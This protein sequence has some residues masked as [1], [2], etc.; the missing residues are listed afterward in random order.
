MATWELWAKSH[1]RV[2]RSLVCRA[3]LPVLWVKLCA[4]DSAGD[5]A[6]GSAGDSAGDNAGDSAGAEEALPDGSPEPVNERTDADLRSHQALPSDRRLLFQRLL[7][8]SPRFLRQLFKELFPSISVL[9]RQALCGA[10]Q[11][12]CQGNG[13]CTR[14]EPWQDTRWGPTAVGALAGFWGGSIGGSQVRRR[15]PSGPGDRGPVA[16]SG[17]ALSL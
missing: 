11:E 5:S 6:G 4:G 2:P 9:P 16:S 13:C 1:H 7:K 15:R 17:L 14:G 3:G 10:K 8:T 12:V